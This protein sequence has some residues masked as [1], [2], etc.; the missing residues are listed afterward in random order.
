MVAKKNARRDAVEAAVRAYAE[1]VAPGRWQA[2]SVMVTIGPGLPPVFVAVTPRTK[3]PRSRGP[4][5]AGPS[6]TQ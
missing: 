4:S 6:G 5:R 2:A 1:A 3:A